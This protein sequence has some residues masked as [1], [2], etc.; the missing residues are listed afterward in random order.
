[1]NPSTLRVDSARSRRRTSASRRETLSFLPPLI[2]FVHLECD[3]KV[4]QQIPSLAKIAYDEG[5]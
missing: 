2:V 5:A 4:S 1:M 3:L